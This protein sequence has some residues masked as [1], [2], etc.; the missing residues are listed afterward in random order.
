MA[1]ISSFV[2][3]Q[4]NLQRVFKMSAVDTYACV[5]SCTPLVNGSNKYS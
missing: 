5:E 4:I 3:T 1:A 2:Y